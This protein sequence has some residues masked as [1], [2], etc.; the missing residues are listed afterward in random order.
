MAKRRNYTQELL[1]AQAKGQRIVCSVAPWVND[2]MEYAPRKKGDPKPWKPV[3]W[4]FPESI[5]RF[6]GR[7]CHAVDAPV[8]EQALAALTAHYAEWIGGSDCKPKIVTEWESPYGT[9]YPQVIMW[10][11]GPDEW[12]LYVTRDCIDIDVKGWPIAVGASPYN[13]WVLS[14]FLQD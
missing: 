6:S 3:G 11:E 7:E 2:A 9:V 1:A 10:E 4:G 8:F 13:G 5:Y 12:P 14:I